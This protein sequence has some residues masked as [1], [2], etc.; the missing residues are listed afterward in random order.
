MA[1]LDL[2]DQP[3]LTALCLHQLGVIAA[4]RGEN[5][6]AV[7][8]LRRALAIEPHQG[9][10]YRSLGTALERMGDMRGAVAALFDLGIMFQKQERHR[11]AVPCYHKV[12][13][14]E[15]L[16]YGAWVNLGTAAAWAGDLAEAVRRLLCGV[17]LY[18]RLV[19]EAAT[20]ARLLTERL[21]GVLERASAWQT[22]PAGEP[23]GPIDKIED[24]LVTLGKALGEL[25]RPEDARLAYKLATTLAPGYPLAHW[26]GALNLLSLGD[27][28]EGWREYEWRWLWD[29]FP[30][31]RRFL[32]LPQWRGT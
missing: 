16:R 19:P 6:R 23:M 32:P 12:L 1:F 2:V 13:S 27:F 9:L 4:H 17:A 28:R 3:S 25:G 26:N 18:G 31:P 8:L 15:P 24:A 29:R 30:E 5:G 22:L 20:L 14:L 7:E 11:D 10:F 21:D